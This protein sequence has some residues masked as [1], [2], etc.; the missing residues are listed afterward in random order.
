MSPLILLAGLTLLRGAAGVGPDTTLTLHRG[1]RVE[2]RG[3][4][5]EVTVQTWERTTM[6]VSAD[7]SELGSVRVSRSD[8]IVAVRPDGRRGRRADVTLKLRVPPWVAL[9]LQGRDLDVRVSG[10]SGPVSVRNVSGDIHV[11]GTSGDLDLST[12]EGEIDVSD[13]R[14]KVS[15]QSRG[16]DVHLT[17]VVGDVDVGT[18]N[19]DVRLDGV[20]AMTVKAETLDGDVYFS[21]AMVKGGRYTFSVHD[22]DA[23]LVIPR[24]AGVH[25]RVA[26]FDGEFSSDFPVTV[27]HF[28]GQGRF[29]FTVGDGGAEASVEVFDGEIRVLASPAGH[30]R[31]R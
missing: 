24:D 30:G 13:A 18:G 22:G 17:R 19:G 26:T 12:V 25:V 6:D 9:D 23:T 10:V 16:D 14:G 21:G 20:Q 5:G 2:L 31:G 8:R 29:E 7:D 1:D 11:T 4:D 27:H 28:T 3:L 15:A